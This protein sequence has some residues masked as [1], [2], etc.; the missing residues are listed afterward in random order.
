[1]IARILLPAIAVLST[2]VSNAQ[3]GA[4]PPEIV[5]IN[6]T[7]NY[8]QHVDFTPSM[9][10]Q[11]KVPN[12]W[13]VTVAASGLGKPRMLANGQ[14]G[15]LYITRRDAGD[16]LLLKDTDGDHRFDELQTIISEFKGV[17]GIALHN[18][19]M[20]LCSNRDLKRYPLKPDGTVGA[21][22][23]LLNDLPD[24]G[25]HGNRTMAFGPDGKLYLSVGSTCNDCMETN[26]ENATM[27]QIDTSSWKR[28]VWARGLR[29][30]IGFDWSPVTQTMFG[31]DNGG[32][33]KGDNWPPE[34]LNEIK[35]DKDYGWPLV[36][37]KQEA[38]E[39]REDPPGTTKQAYAKTTEPSILEFPAHSAPIAFQFFGNSAMVPDSLKDDG[40]VC[41]HGSWNK[42]NP[43]GFKV[44]RIIFENG[45]AVRAVDFL[46]GFYDRNKRTR[47]GRPAGLTI[48]ADGAVFISDDANGIIYCVEQKK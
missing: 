33:A 29:N 39:T 35:Q 37:A 32:D 21:E 18:G 47:F 11:L 14:Q 46:S 8:P 1:M 2:F 24:G 6:H 42:K 28:V 26:K 38:D 25:Q 45:K 3:K 36:Y 23:W 44:Q 19:W 16:V 41:W 31:V 5:N 17:H 27:L 48:A 20:Y 9:I 30:T 13:K 10:N 34:E 40:L 7:T 43:D 15:E 4:P 12:G 22:Q